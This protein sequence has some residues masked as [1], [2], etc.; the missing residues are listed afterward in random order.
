MATYSIN[1]H[2]VQTL[3]DRYY[4]ISKTKTC[5]VN[6]KTNKFILDKLEERKNKKI[7]DS[8]SNDRAGAQEMFYKKGVLRKFCGNH[9]EK[10][11]LDSLS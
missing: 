8:S 1:N 5:K 2:K 10:P 11:V 3:H 9:R 6:Q 7:G 4:S